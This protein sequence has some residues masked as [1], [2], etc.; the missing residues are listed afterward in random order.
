MN[1][2]I[3]I[4]F[5]AILVIFIRGLIYNSGWDIGGSLLFIGD[6][7]TTIKFVGFIVFF[8]IFLIFIFILN[9][10]KKKR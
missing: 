9:R 1:G 7:F 8:I 6:I 3:I 10:F 2:W 4:I 5:V